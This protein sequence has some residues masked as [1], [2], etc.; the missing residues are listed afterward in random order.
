M[1]EYVDKFLASVDSIARALGSIADSLNKMANPLHEVSSVSED[2]EK[3][4]EETAE[5]I[6][7]VLEEATV[8]AVEPDPLPQLPVA[9]VL[10]KCKPNLETAATAWMLA[11]GAHHTVYSQAIN[12]AFMD[13]FADIARIEMLVID[14]N[15]QIRDFKDKLNANEVY[16]HLLPPAY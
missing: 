9:R 10:W 16:Y 14:Q 3:H 11:G 8:E 4:I 6:S 5:Q 15:T 7:E 1:M 2:T 13:D 12:T